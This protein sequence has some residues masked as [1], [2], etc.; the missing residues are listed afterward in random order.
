VAECIENRDAGTEQRRGFGGWQLVWD[1]GD[2]LG[3][4]EHVFLVAAVVTDAR[5][6]FVLAVDEIAAAAGIA[7]EIVT[8]VPSY[9]D[10]LAGLPVRNVAADSVDAAGD[11][12]SGNAWILD[13]GPIAFLYQLV[14]V[15]D[16][17]G[18]DFNADLVSARLGDV[19]FDEF[20]IASGFADLDNFHLRHGFPS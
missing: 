9:S 3:G 4:C 13:S 7:G 1:G 10:A 6:L 2:R 17:A 16:A 11:F 14:T 20:E 18:F 5:N 8:T 19:S 12:M 15:A